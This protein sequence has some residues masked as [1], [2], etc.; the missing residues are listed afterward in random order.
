MYG[1]YTSFPYNFYARNNNIGY[2]SIQSFS[3]GTAIPTGSYRILSRILKPFGLREENDGWQLFLS[4]AFNISNVNDTTSSSSAVSSSTSTISGTVSTDISASITASTNSDVASTTSS[5]ASSTTSGGVS[6]SPTGLDI[7][8][9]IRIVDLNTR[10]NTMINPNNWF[11]MEFDILSEDPIAQ[12][13]VVQFSVPEELTDLP[14]FQLMTTGGNLLG[15][16]NYDDDKHMATLTFSSSWASGRS[17]IRGTP[18][19]MIRLREPSSIGLGDK[20]FTFKTEDRTF[21]N[22][23]NFPGIPTDTPTKNSRYVEDDPSWD[24]YI[25]GELGPWTS[26]RITS[27]LTTEDDYVYLC[28]SISVSVGSEYDETHNLTSSTEID[29]SGYT[30]TCV[31]RNLDVTINQ[32]IATD[33]ML[34]FTIDGERSLSWITT[35]GNKITVAITKPDG[36][37]INRSLSRRDTKEWTLAD[38]LRRDPSHESQVMTGDVYVAS[39]TAA[40][41]SSASESSISPATSSGVSSSATSS[42]SSSESSS[43]FLATSSGAS[44]AT[45]S[46]ASSSASSG[47]TSIDASSSASSGV[48]SATSSGASSGATSTDASSGA[49]SATSSGASS[50]TSSGA[51]LAG[52]SSG[53]SSG[54]AT[55]TSSI[56]AGSGS[57]SATGASSTQAGSGSGSATGASSTQAGSG[58]G[59]ATGASTPAG[60]GSTTGTIIRSGSATGTIIRSGSAT[61]SASR[62]ASGVLSSSAGSASAS[63]TI[64]A[65]G[66]GSSS[67]PAET[68][69]FASS[70][71]T[72]TVT[73]VC[74][75]CAATPVT[76]TYTTT[77]PCENT[78]TAATP[79]YTTVT[80]TSVCHS[81]A[82]TPVTVTYTTTVPCETTGT[83]ATIV[84][85]VTS[86]CTTCGETPVTSTYTVTRT[87]S[88]GQTTVVNNA[89]T[90][91]VRE[92]Q[93]S[94]AASSSVVAGLVNSSAAGNKE[95]AATTIRVSSVGLE[96]GG[97]PIASASEFVA[98][99]N[100]YVYSSVIGATRTAA[101]SAVP[102]NPSSAAHV[103]SSGVEH[104]NGSP[105]QTTAVADT[106][107]EHDANSVST[108]TSTIFVQASES[109]PTSAN[110]GVAGVNTQSG[111]AG[112]GSSTTIA[113]VNSA[114]SNGMT[115]FSTLCAALVSCVLLF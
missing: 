29:S 81:C 6:P 79:S 38:E 101:I 64:S 8:T 1:G 20:T 26:V 112:S 72:I 80:V 69:G 7:I 56:P 102:V 60:S 13:A 12:G 78:G 14:S 91:Q 82:A 37:I 58:S 93:H 49:S 16:L 11:Y 66:S 96:Y 88:A 76:V 52:T 43:A 70:F 109:K 19:M 41:S 55:G 32:Q 75:S 106:P 83:A 24:V 105:S 68:S 77:V 115:F 98:N 99:S 90:S 103:S 30:T 57:G 2:I 45:S 54:S 62:S 4:G 95:P 97:K 85:N 9:D 40:T 114:S 36:E 100:I 61:S 110:T 50:A 46:G 47:S 3:N 107:S 86:V 53:A 71:T 15:T 27:T 113:Q 34:K 28:D 33:D 73:S 84:E 39:S 108:S 18:R 63:V 92:V 17:N 25:P 94:H 74:H 67:A 111:G 31:I 42:V 59:S 89:Q 104:A 10:T 21:D 51:S 48:S 44:S 22:V 87:V 35:F 23:I 5:V 65:P